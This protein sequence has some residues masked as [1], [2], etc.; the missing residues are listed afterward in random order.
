MAYN[1][2]L[3]AFAKEAD[4]NDYT[5][6]THR[7][8]FYSYP[9]WGKSWANGNDCEFHRVHTKCHLCDYMPDRN[10]AG[11]GNMYLLNNGCGEETILVVKKWETKRGVLIPITE[12][13]PNTTRLSRMII[14]CPDHVGSYFRWNENNYVGKRKSVQLEL[15]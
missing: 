7:N 8:F 4:S 6:F 9:E 10:Y 2:N 3:E 15:F 5:M 12:R 14:L 11:V 1:D 13:V